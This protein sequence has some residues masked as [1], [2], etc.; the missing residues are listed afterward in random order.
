LT[1][2][3][4]PTVTF[5]VLIP[6]AVAFQDKKVERQLTNWTRTHDLSIISSHQFTLSSSLTRS[7]FYSDLKT[8]LFTKSFPP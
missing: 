3:P 7:V 1:A 2:L 4:R 6:R 5:L 8:W